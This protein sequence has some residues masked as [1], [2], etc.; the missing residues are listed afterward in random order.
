MTDGELLRFLDVTSLRGDETAAECID[1]ARRVDEAP[2]PPS[3]LCIFPDALAAVDAAFPERA[4]AL[5][6]VV[7]FP[8]GAADPDAVGRAVEAAVAAGAEEIDAVLA[9]EAFFARDYGRVDAVFAAVRTAAPTVCFKAILETGDPRYTPT[10]LGRAADRALD[11]GANFLKTSTG[12]IP[13]GA[14][15][16]AVNLLCDAI[17]KAPVGIKVSGGVRTREAAH[18]YVACVEQR[19]APESLTPRRFRIGASDL[20]TQLLPRART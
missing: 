9:L 8:S 16:E 17:G 13:V 3:A 11:A 12:K 5:A 1:L 20:F 4:W 2:G 19:F 7:N 18:A 14:T 6:T 10:L 15:L